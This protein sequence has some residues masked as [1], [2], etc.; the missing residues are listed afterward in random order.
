MDRINKKL[1]F[2]Y[3][4]TNRKSCHPKPLEEVILEA[5]HSG[6]RFIQLREKDLNS[7]DLHILAKKIKTLTDRYKALL[8]INGNVDIALAVDADGVHLPEARMP[9]AEVRKRL[10]NNKLI[11]KSIHLPISLS[12]DDY[13][14]IDFVTLSPVYSP[15]GKNYKAETIGVCNL[16]KTI[17]EIPVPVYALGGIKPNH[18]IELKRAGAS[19]IALSSGIMQAENIKKRVKEYLK[20]F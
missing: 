4:I 6:I 12:D 8:L 13:N 18:I 5:L 1:P 7:R 2:L 20:V 10:G 19:G 17:S 16:K 14:Y 15:G 3:L 11:G 9:V